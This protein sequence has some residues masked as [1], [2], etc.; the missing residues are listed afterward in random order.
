MYRQLRSFAL[1]PLLATAAA[2]GTDAVGDSS[3][4]TPDGLII[5]GDATDGS[6]PNLDAGAEDGTSPDATEPDTTEPDATQPDTSEPDATEPDTTEPDTTEPDTTEPDAT[7][8]DVTEPDTS[9]P[10]VTEPD[11]TE[12]DTSEDGACTNREDLATL[13]AS[14]DLE[15]AI[16]T[17]A[18]SCIRGG[19]ACATPCIEEETG[20][21]TECS[22][23]FGQI[24]ECTINNCALQCISPS[25]PACTRCQADNCQPAFVECSGVTPP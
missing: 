19:E 18:R 5:G 23:C 24:I 6:D 11:T 25:N 12:P 8:P 21:S 22:T 16:G 14:R 4:D 9:E 2:C 10:D 17:C 7:E 1:L 15:D 13:A 3:T 20:L